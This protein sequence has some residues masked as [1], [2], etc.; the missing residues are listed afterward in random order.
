MPNE[1][2]ICKDCGHT[3]EEHCPHIDVLDGGEI[4][5]TCVFQDKKRN[6]CDCVEFIENTTTKE[7]KESEDD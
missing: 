5:Y 2:D 1:D 6:F 3:Y 7:R 4:Q